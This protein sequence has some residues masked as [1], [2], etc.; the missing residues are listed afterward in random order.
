[1]GPVLLTNLGC[2]SADRWAATPWTWQRN[3]AEPAGDGPTSVAATDP[4]VTPAAA[5]DPQVTEAFA[6]LEQA[7]AEMRQRQSD[8]A[9]SIAQAS[10]QG[11]PTSV[12]PTGA[13]ASK[14]R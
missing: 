13:E 2:T 4:T 11:S 7:Q 10:R 9:E 12:P 3:A 5:E 6:R 14:V 8:A 1:M